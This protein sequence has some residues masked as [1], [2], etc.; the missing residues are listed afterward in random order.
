MKRWKA[1]V[2]AF[3]K[4]FIRGRATAGFDGESIAL[5]PDIVTIAVDAQG[6]IEIEGS[7]ARFRPFSQRLH[8]LL[9]LPL[10]VEVVLFDAFIIVGCAQPS[11]ARRCLPVIPGLPLTFDFGPK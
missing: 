4:K 3:G 9:S 8:L 6:K 7:A 2:L 10:Y 1:P 5:A 11:F